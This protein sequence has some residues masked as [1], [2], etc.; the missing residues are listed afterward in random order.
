[1][2]HE[3]AVSN[4]VKVQATSSENLSIFNHQN[5]NFSSLKQVKVAAQ[6]S[7]GGQKSSNYESFCQNYTIDRVKY[8]DSHQSGMKVNDEILKVQ[9]VQSAPE[10]EPCAKSQKC[11]VQK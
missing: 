7:R 1:M 9:P 11:K 3:S 8:S 4:R 10:E 5:M 6:S 2:K